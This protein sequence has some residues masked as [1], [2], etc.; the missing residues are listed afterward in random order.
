MKSIKIIFLFIV[1]HFFAPTNSYAIIRQVSEI[2]NIEARRKLQKEEKFLI[3]GVIFLV[4][5]IYPF[6]K[7][8]IIQQMATNI[9]STAFG[10]LMFGVGAILILV[11]LVAF[12]SYFVEKYRRKQY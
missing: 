2:P 1:F 4:L 11:S 12:G 5:G 6:V 8:I 10:V 9:I 7:G 3:L